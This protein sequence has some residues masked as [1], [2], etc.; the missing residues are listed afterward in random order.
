MPDGTADRPV[1]DADGPV[2]VFGG[3]ASNLQATE[4]LFAEARRLGVPPARMICT[5]DIVAYGAD[6]E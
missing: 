6:P 5:G 1:L 2:L 4:A 3:C